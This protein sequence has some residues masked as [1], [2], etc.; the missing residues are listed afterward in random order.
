MCSKKRE[1]YE[2]FLKSVQ[3]FSTIEPYEMTKIMDA[4]K[5]TDFPAG[6]PIIQEVR[7]SS[8]GSRA[9]KATSSSSWPPEK[10]T[11]PK[12]SPG[13]SPSKSWTTIKAP[14]SANSLSSKTPLEPPV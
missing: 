11:P 13:K 14:T 7:T 6:T 1:K 12:K 5:P 8:H 3:I 2:E 10:P 9:R 4:V